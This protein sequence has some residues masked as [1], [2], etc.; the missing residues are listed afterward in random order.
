MLRTDR[1][2]V[3]R[4]RRIQRVPSLLARSL[5]FPSELYFPCD[6]RAC[7]RSSCI[8]RPKFFSPKLGLSDSNIGYVS[9]TKVPRHLIR[10][11]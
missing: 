4:R 11:S 9:T 2:R 10:D 5:R 8:L 7:S 6:R 1:R 3:E